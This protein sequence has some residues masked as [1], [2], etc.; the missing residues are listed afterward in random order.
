MSNSAIGADIGEISAATKPAI[1]IGATTGAARIFAM[2]LMG[3]MYPESATMT[4][5]QSAIAAIGGA[6]IFGRIFGAI[7]S[8]PAV[9]RTESAKPGSRA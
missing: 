1:V 5:E 3:L 7:S 9:A 6:K 8:R 2:M 4:G